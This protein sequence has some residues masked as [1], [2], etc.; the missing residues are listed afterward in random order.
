MFNP[1]VLKQSFHGV[2]VSA[3]G[4]IVSKVFQSLEDL[5]FLDVGRSA[6][7]RNHRVCQG[8]CCCNNSPRGPYHC[9][10]G[11]HQQEPGKEQSQE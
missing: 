2:A 10:L 8:N 5:G 9:P 4:V 11:V 1:F 3:R 7:I 6:Y